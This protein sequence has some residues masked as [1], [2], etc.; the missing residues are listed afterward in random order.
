MAVLSLTKARQYFFLNLSSVL[1]C[2]DSE[3]F[4]MISND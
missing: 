2:M 4:Y 3:M 1:I